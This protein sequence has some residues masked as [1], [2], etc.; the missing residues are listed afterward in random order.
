[1]LIYLLKRNDAAGWDEMEG[2]VVIASSEHAA[3]EL[4]AQGAVAESSEIW[5]NI[6][7][8]DCTILGQASSEHEPS[9]Y[10]QAVLWG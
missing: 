5:M 1:M 2:C 8:C 9:I 3:R 4:A 6:E 7:L 10:L